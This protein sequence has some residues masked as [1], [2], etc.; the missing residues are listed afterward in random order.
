M[1][2]RLLRTGTVFP[3]GSFPR[4]WQRGC[5]ESVGLPPLGTVFGEVLGCTTEASGRAEPPAAATGPRRAKAG[6][7]G[8]LPG[9]GKRFGLHPPRGCSRGLVPLANRPAREAPGSSAVPVPVPVPAKGLGAGCCS[10]SSVKT[11]TRR[12]CPGLC[13][14]SAALPALG[15]NRGGDSL[16]PGRPLSS[17]PPRFATPRNGH[18]TM[19]LADPLVSCWDGFL[20]FKAVS[21]AAVAALDSTDTISPGIISSH[22]SNTIN[23]REVMGWV[24]MPTQLSCKTGGQVSF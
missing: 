19:L 14:A 11:R 21:D 5:K 7:A 17:A 15:A 23:R 9:G 12:L 10:Q 13:G 22:T 2:Q 16:C 20:G 24:T 1:Q 3:E 4:S 8:L 6:V 18:Q